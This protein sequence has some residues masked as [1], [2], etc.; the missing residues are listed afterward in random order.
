M[1][2]G[3]DNRYGEDICVGFAIYCDEN[4]LTDEEGL[5]LA[6]RLSDGLMAVAGDR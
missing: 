1:A 5:E 6:E 3:D 4:G 2:E